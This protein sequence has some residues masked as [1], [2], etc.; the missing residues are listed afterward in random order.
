MLPTKTESRLR[1]TSSLKTKLRSMTLIAGLAYGLCA[2]LAVATGV[3]LN[4]SDVSITLTSGPSLLVDNNK[5]CD[6]E[7]H[8]AFV[9]FEVCNT[10]SLELTNLGLR[11]E[12]FTNANFGLAGGQEVEQSID[13]LSVGECKTMFWYVYYDCSADRLSS[14]L[15]L[16]I[17]ETSG[18]TVTHTET[19]TTVSTID[20]GAGGRILSSQLTGGLSI[21]DTVEVACEYSIGSTQAGNPVIIQPAGNLDF[22][23]DCYQLV[24]SVVTSSEVSE[25]VV[26][27]TDQLY[28]PNVSKHNGNSHL[29]T[30]TYTFISNCVT[31]DTTYLRGYSAAVS[32]SNLKRYNVGDEVLSSGPT[33][34]VSWEN[35]EVS[36]EGRYARISWKQSNNDPEDLLQVERSLDSRL[37]E[38]IYSASSQEFTQKSNAF[39]YLDKLSAKQLEQKLY[40]RLKHIDLN[41]KISFSSILELEVERLSFNPIIYPNPV[42]DYINIDFQGFEIEKAEIR[43]S[44]LLGKVVYQKFLPAA[45]SEKEVISLQDLPPGNYFLQ[46]LHPEYPFSESFIKQ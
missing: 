15:S 9:S 17:F 1:Q 8:A 29:F 36:R 13:T 30:L 28:Y 27:D 42:N 12:D 22:D 7:P 25:I 35:L 11:L 21:G 46:I 44:N 6:E 2:T 26:G 33:L 4:P 37:F 5:G 38:N 24:S 32:G 31:T 18:D 34:D 39:I 19:L 41:G 16:K 10:S 20:A 43:I 45:H 23:A 3:N 14:D 40:Y